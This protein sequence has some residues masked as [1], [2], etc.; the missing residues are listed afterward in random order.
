MSSTYSWGEKICVFQ[1]I[2]QWCGSSCNKY[3]RLKA[4]QVAIGIRDN[5][6]KGRAQLIVVEEGSEP[7]ELKEVL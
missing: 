2:Y 6:R 4:S 3:E 7:L 1:E 5:E